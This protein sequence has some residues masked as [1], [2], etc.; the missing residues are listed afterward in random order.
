MTPEKKPLPMWLKITAAAT[1][2][3]GIVSG[4]QKLTTD[5]PVHFAVVGQ[6]PAQAEGWKCE[7][8]GGLIGAPLVCRPTTELLKTDT[9]TETK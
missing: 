8:E 5:S 1:A 4:G 2:G 9:N 7:P 3:A 6:P